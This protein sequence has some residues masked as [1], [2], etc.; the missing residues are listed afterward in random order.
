MEI[1]GPVA[2][3]E[4]DAPGAV[5]QS[6]LERWHRGSGHPH[7]RRRGQRDPARPDLHVRRWASR[8]RVADG[9]LLHPPTRRTSA[10]W[11]QDPRR[12][13][14]ARAPEGGRRPPRSATDLDLWSDARRRRPR[15]HLAARVGRR[16]RAR[17]SSRPASCSRR[18]AAPAAPVPALAVMALAAPASWQA[19][20]CDR[21]PRRR[22]RRRRAS[23]PRRCTSRSATRTRRRPTVTD[24]KLTGEK[25]CVPAGLVAT[26]FV[27]SATDGLYL[28]DAVAAGRHRRAPGHH[29]RRSPRLCVTF[30]GADGASRSAGPMASRGCST[31]PR[32]MTCVMIAACLRRPRSSLTAELREGR[33]SSSTA[34]IATFQAVSQRTADAYIDN[35][36]IRLTAWQAAWRLDARSRR[37]PTQ[38]ATAKFWAAEG[39][40]T[41][42]RTPRTTCT[43]AWASTA[44]TRC[45]AT[46]CAASWS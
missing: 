3:L 16:R 1:L 13:L 2:Y 12:R 34:P 41:G 42:S 33:A 35:E 15:R 6:R 46:S 14:H 27:V 11:R 26:A 30:D 37:R 36:A 8:E 28:V 31:G 9:L 32:P 24:G 45:T 19:D 38:V 7:L 22:R 4:P 44:T 10:S 18:S 40:Q 17:A 5:L 21:R 43:A 29:D 39:G 20:R 25:V 23:S